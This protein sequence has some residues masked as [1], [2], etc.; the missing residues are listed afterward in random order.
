M[1]TTLKDVNIHLLGLGDSFES[2]G[3]FMGVSNTPMIWTLIAKHSYYYEF[4]ITYHGIY[5]NT[6]LVYPDTNKIVVK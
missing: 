2:K 3:L 4:K 1:I 5:I 6:M